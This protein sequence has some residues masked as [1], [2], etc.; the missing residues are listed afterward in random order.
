MLGG[1]RLRNRLWRKAV[2]P[3]VPILGEVAETPIPTS[4]L[5]VGCQATSESDPL[6]TV[7]SDP[8]TL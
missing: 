7:K 8:L 3:A 6:A 1:Y 5:I 2:P 4:I